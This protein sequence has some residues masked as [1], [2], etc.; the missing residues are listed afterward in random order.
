MLS[1]I[2]LER[3]LKQEMQGVDNFIDKK[4]DEA[5][6]NLSARMRKENAKKVATAVAS[7]LVGKTPYVGGILS[8]AVK[9]ITH[10]QTSGE[11][12]DSAL[13]LYNIADI[14][15]KE[16][17]SSVTE[18]TLRKFAK[19]QLYIELADELMNCIEDNN[20]AF[21][22]AV[23]MQHQIKGNAIKPHLKQVLKQPE[24]MEMDTFS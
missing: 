1:N 19:S 10:E 13:A 5:K 17:H 21:I 12:L 9:K 15:S 23:K 20:T 16:I 22:Q 2:E 18:K 6:L 7:Y 24:E 4:F 3:Q 11:I 8:Y 14:Y